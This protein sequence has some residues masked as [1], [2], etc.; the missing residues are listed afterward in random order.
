MQPLCEPSLDEVLADGAVRQLM[1][2][3]GVSE[4]A[5]RALIGTIRRKRPEGTDGAAAPT[6]GSQPCFW[7]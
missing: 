2:K 6:R 7:L 5:L 3:D 4:S 1:A